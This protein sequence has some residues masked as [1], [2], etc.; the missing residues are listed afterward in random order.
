MTDFGG[1]RRNFFRRAFGDVVKQAGR[2]TENRVVQQRYVRPPGALPEVAFLTACTRCHA[3]SDVCPA[4]VILQV[5]A[6]GGLAAGTP[7][8]EPARMPCVACP[9]MPCVTACPTGA[10]TMPPGGW[11]TER[12]GSIEFHPDRC[13]TF[14]GKPCGVCVRACPIGEAALSLDDEGRPVLK[15]E[16]CVACG[17]CVRDCITIPSSFTFHPLEL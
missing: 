7:Y 9:D 3:C 8:L 10:L 11:R 1:D 4:G 12:L 2:M 14:E 17:V 5:T 6:R 16:G 15:A 13:V